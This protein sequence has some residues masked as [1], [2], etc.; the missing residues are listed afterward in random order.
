[1]DPSLFLAS[2]EIFEIGG[3]RKGP[4]SLKFSPDSSDQFF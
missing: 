2:V 1:M 4:S 3:A